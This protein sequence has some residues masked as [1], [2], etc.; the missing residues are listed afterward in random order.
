MV[1]M[2]AVNVLG[3]VTTATAPFLVLPLPLLPVL[4]DLLC[5]CHKD[6]MLFSYTVRS[7]LVIKKVSV[8][9]GFAIEVANLAGLL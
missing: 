9:L 8:R 2:G 6:T 4:H 7:P 1:V 3:A 5:C